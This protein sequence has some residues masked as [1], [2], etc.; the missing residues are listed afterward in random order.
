MSSLA[1]AD[2]KLLPV[3]PVLVKCYFRLIY[4]YTSDYHFFSFFLFFLEIIIHTPVPH[5]ITISPF[6]FTTDIYTVQIL[7][8]SS[9]G[10]NVKIHYPSG[11]L[12][13]DQMIARLYYDYLFN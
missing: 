2:G 12:L 3:T 4:N 1:K 7:F 8:F 10:L 6:L 9:Y 5:T 11:I 13:D